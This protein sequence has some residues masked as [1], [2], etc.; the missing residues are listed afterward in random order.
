MQAINGT[1]WGGWGLSGLNFALDAVSAPK[2]ARCSA[3][4]NFTNC[5]GV[6]IGA[7]MGAFLSA[8]APEIIES[9]APKLSLVSPLYLVFLVA[10]VAGFIVVIFFLPKFHEVRP[11]SEPDYREMVYMFTHLKPITGI[12]LRRRTHNDSQAM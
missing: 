2:R 7:M 11:V 12:R 3:Y 1:I 9:V 10:S 5:M 4:M 8:K 6:V